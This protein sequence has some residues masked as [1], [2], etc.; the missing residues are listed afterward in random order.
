MEPAR[1]LLP[2]PI[3]TNHLFAN[4]PGRGRITSKEYQAWKK[5]AAQLLTAQRC[6]RF[7]T[8][9]YISI[10]V[11]EVDVGAAMDSDN[12][13]K[14]AIDALKGAQIIVDDNRRWV[15]SSRATWI[16]GFRGMVAIVAPATEPP[17][18]DELRRTIPPSIWEAMQG[19]AKKH[20]R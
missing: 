20:Q 18:A 15:R 17:T 1:V 19:H 12:T 8:P 3:S 2:P 13:L 10:M 9:V 7:T 11:G 5:A 4:V 6:P 14:A 16:P